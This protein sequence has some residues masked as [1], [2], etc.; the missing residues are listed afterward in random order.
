MK[1]SPRRLLSISAVLMLLTAFAHTTGNLMP[2]DPSLIDAETRMRGYRFDFGLGM[3]PSMFD[4]FMLLVLIM[5]VTFIAF[6]VLNLALANAR[7]FPD[8]LLRPIVW[9]N[10]VWV[11]VFIALCWFYRAP[12]PLISGVVIEIPLMAALLVRNPGSSRSRRR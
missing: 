12:P 4:V 6:G 2:S 8:R 3:S 10:V 9:I 1:L 5:T 7:D 11:A